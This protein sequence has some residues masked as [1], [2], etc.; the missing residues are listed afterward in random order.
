MQEPPATRAS[1]L[2]RIRDGRDTEAW[3]QFLEVYASL[4]YGFARKRG[5]QDADA[6][7]LMQEVLRSV[8]SAAGRLEYDPGRGSFR[9]WLYT[10]TR[11]KLTNFLHSRQR[12]LRGSGDTD[13]LERLEE[14][15]ARADGPVEWDQEYE[16]RLF[17]WAAERVRGEFK[18]PTWQ[19]FWQTAVE[20]RA[21]KEVAEALGLSVG[22][23]YVAKSRVLAR[24]KEE[25]QRIEGA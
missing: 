8:A 11:N 24:L 18:E 16:R 22:A 14:Q 3:R 4:I 2:V 20:D 23:V 25:V 10:V 17:T 12:R 21:A 13:E 7:D 9:G 19:A 1:L 15:T 6:A 5:L